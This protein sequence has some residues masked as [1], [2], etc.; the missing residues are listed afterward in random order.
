[1]SDANQQVELMIQDEKLAVGEVERYLASQV[2]EIRVEIQ[3]SASN[4]QA[5]R[6]RLQQLSDHHLGIVGA[7]NRAHADLAKL[8]VE[9]TK[10]AEPKPV[11]LTAES[12]K[13][14]ADKQK[15]AKLE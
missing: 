8:I 14:S 3:Q 10:Q 1:M 12:A 15:K 2:R 4:I 9:R 7:H 6:E 13:K 5:L 11:E